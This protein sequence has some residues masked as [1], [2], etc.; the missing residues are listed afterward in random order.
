MDAANI[1]AMTMNKNTGN[2]DVVMTAGGLWSFQRSDSFEGYGCFEGNKIRAGN[3]W[4]GW[5]AKIS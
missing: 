3:L 2:A 1:V 4:V 5:T